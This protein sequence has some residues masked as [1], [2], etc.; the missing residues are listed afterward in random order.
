MPG[1]SR[2]SGRS[3]IGRIEKRQDALDLG[4]HI[5]AHRTPIAT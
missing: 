5:G 4:D 1:R 3:A 2:A